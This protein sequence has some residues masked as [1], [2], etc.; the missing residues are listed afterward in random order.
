M[1]RKEAAVALAAML[2]AVTALPA[3]AQSADE[4]RAL[5]ERAAEHIR[6]F[7]PQQAFVD[8]SRPDGGFVN[9]SLYVFCHDA[10]GTVLA[11][12]GNPRLVGRTLGTMRDVEGRRT[13]AEMSRIGEVKG[14]GWLEYLWPNP[15]EGRIQRKRSW[16]FQINAGAVCGS[17][18]YEPDRP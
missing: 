6:L 2:F 18:Y 16:V 1:I 5:A 12:G 9:G 3:L 10:A 14:E 17:G 8:F 15:R 4:A 13:V 11:N 7:G